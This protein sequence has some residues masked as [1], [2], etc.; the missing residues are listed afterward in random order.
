MR[1]IGVV[2]TSRADYGIYRPILQA[3]EISDE[4]ELR[5][6]VSG[7]HLQARLGHT[8][9]QIEQDGYRIQARIGLDLDNDSAAA[10]A[11]ASG[12]ATVG[13]ADAFA[14]WQ[15]DLLLVLGD[16]YEMH[17]AAVA[18]LPLAIPVA[19]IHGGELTFGAIDDSLR[20]SL[21]KLSHLHFAATE[22]YGRRIVQMGEAP[23]RVTVCGAPSLDNLQGFVPWTPKELEQRFGILWHEGMLLATYHPVTLESAQTDRQIESLIAALEPLQRPVLF[24]KANADTHGQRINRRLELWAQNNPLIQLVD[25]LGTQGYFSAMTHA[26]AMVGNSSSGLLEAASFALPTVNIGTRQ[27]GRVRGANVIDCG[28]ETEQILTALHQ[29]LAPEYRQQLQGKPNPYGN[30]TATEK[31]IN[32]LRSVELGSSLVVKKFHDQKES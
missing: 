17:A 8:V 28:D 25:N 2:T 15:P 13:F 7:S 16:R 9:D 5:L 26:A 21:T 22:S 4:F 10:I 18:A 19:H 12:Q 31:I 32:V 1:T 23:W 20:H 24:T 29:V 11:R 30:G 27:E 3:L 6:F 14:Q